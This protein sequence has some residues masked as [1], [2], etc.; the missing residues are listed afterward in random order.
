MQASQKPVGG[1][2]FAFVFGYE[3]MHSCLRALI[4]IS[5]AAPARIA[6]EEK[7][8]SVSQA[9]EGAYL[10][11]RVSRQVHND[12]GTVIE[13][14]MRSRKGPDGR[15]LALGQQADTSRQVIGKMSRQ[16]AGPQCFQTDLSSHATP[17]PAAADDS[18]GGKITE[19]SYVVRIKMRYDYPAYLARFN[20]AGFKLAYRVI[21][22]RDLDRSGHTV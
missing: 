1:V 3:S 11:G 10:A 19:S 8:P 9:H 15:T 18:S 17:C 14:V 13:K 21:G 6:G 12:D 2:L 7:S 20:A 22:L 16:K 5:G 4:S